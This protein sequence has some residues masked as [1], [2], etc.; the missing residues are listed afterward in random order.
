L[1]DT[2]FFNIPTE[3]K[4]K[5]SKP[6]TLRPDDGLAAISILHALLNSGDSK[7]FSLH[8]S[9]QM[10]PTFTAR[11]YLATILAPFQ[12][13]EYRDHKQKNHPLVEA[14]I[15]DSLKLGTQNHYLDGIPVLF[16]AT[17]L[18]KAQVM[19]NSLDRVR[20]GLILRN[21]LIHNSNTGSHWTSSILF[22]LVTELIPLYDLENDLMDSKKW[23]FC[24]SFTLSLI[25]TQT[26]VEV[27]S[28]IIQSYNSFVNKIHELDLTNDVEARPILNVRFFFIETCSI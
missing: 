24:M 3:V 6:F 23:L 8:S 13:I 7:P 19:D 1:Y 21:K 12:G 22:T 25:Q 14:V 27:A 20:L 26:Q 9:L 10:D 5:I 28:R 4:S 2:I 15:R 17:R 18:I 11:L 16:A